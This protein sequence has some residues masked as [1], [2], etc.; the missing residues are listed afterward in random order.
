MGSKP[1]HLV[2]KQDTNGKSWLPIEKIDGM[3]AG[4]DR[5]DLITVRAEHLDC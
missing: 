2:S 3:N 1:V 4:F 5:R